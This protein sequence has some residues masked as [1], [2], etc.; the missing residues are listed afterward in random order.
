MFLVG[1]LLGL[2][3]LAVLPSAY[4]TFSLLLVLCVVLFNSLVASNIGT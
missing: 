3:A 1:L 2:G 4:W